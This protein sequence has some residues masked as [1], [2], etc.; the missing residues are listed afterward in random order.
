[1]KNILILTYV[2]PPYVAVGGYRILK[3]CKYLPEFGYNP[4]ILTPAKPN[5]MAYDENMLS[6]VDRSVKIYRT[7][8]FEPFAWKPT[9]QSVKKETDKKPAAKSNSDNQSAQTPSLLDKIKRTIKLNLSI[10]DSSYFWSRYG[11]DDGMKAI[12]DEKIDLIVS[13]APPQ[14]VHLLG[15]NL[16][17]KSGLPHLLDFRDLWTQNTSYHEKNLPAYLQKRDRKYEL[18]VL[19][20]A[21][22]VTVN[23]ETFKNQLLDKNSFLESDII[24]TVTNGVDPDD[25]VSYVGKKKSDDKFCMVYTGSLYGQHRNPEFF[26]KALASWIERREDLK[27]KIYVKF[28]G[29][30]SPGFENLIPKYKLENIVDHVGWAPQAEAFEELFKADLLL[31]FQGF[32]PVLNAAIPRKLFEYMI[33]NKDI[34]AFAPPGEIPAMIGE[35]NCGKCLS[36]QELEPIIKILED[37]YSQWQNSDKKPVE[38]LRNMSKLE[39]KNQIQKLAGLCD[40]ILTDG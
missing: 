9:Q 36:N 18:K 19:Q 8:T 1:M 28:I 14:S 38:Q 15:Y 39:T 26:F 7:K 16:S 5:T 3:F 22:G 35:Y 37:Y 21:S 10:P 33:T 25:F 20:N 31:L 2:F 30:W 23:T 4:V 17:R 34:L 29:N 24:E 27:D 12:K 11:M 13:S 32:D 6:L 40:K